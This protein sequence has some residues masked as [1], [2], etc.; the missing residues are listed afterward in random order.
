MSMIRRYPATH[1]SWD[2]FVPMTRDMMDTQALTQ[3]GRPDLITYGR[4]LC[5]CVCVCFMLAVR[6]VVAM[7]AAPM[8]G[9]ESC[10]ENSFCRR[11]N[12]GHTSLGMLCSNIR[13][14]GDRATWHMRVSC[15]ECPAGYR[16]VTVLGHGY[17]ISVSAGRS[18]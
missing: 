3:I 8:F 9:T 14:K 11:F 12:G 4:H 16:G 5:G 18:P 7:A 2:D 17:A 15:C 10:G 6:V 13:L 1:A